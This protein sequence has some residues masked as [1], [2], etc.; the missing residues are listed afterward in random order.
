MSR[1]RGRPSTAARFW[2]TIPQILRWADEYHRN[3][4]KWPTVNSGPVPGTKGL[5]WRSIHVALYKG[6]R[7]LPGGSSLA[8]LLAERRGARNRRNLP[9]LTVARILSWADAYHQ[10]EGRWPAVASGPIPQAPGETWVG[11]HV[12]LVQGRR[13]LRGRSSL[14]RLLAEERG[15]RMPVKPS[16]LTEK[17]VLKWADAFH[18]RTGQWPKL[19]SGRV[20]SAPAENWRT[21]D[22][23]LAEG[24]RGL[25]GGS[26]LAQLLA[27][28]R[29]A[30]ILRRPPRLTEKQILSWADAHYR[31]TGQWPR[32]M[33]GPIPEQPGGGDLAPGLLR[34][35]HRSAWSAGRIIA[36]ETA[37]CPQSRASKDRSARPEGSWS[38]QCEVVC[39][40]HESGARRPDTVFPPKTRAE[41][42]VIRATGCLFISRCTPS[43]RRS[44]FRR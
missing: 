40:P 20:P 13:G 38:R 11:V 16:R 4:G 19:R 17:Q 31:G 8:R 1:R 39:Q 6:F 42:A 14:A 30:R 24:R 44:W 37:G 41:E 10:R 32:I 29:G 27:H 5:T 9:E 18:H 35:V 26:S 23:A 21:L 3:A 36:A 7:G 43:L 15:R 34:A 33:S 2:L 22:N 28:R 25:P 12:A